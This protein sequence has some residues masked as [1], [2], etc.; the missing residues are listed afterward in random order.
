MSEGILPNLEVAAK[1]IAIFGGAIGGFFGFLKLVKY[2]ATSRKN[3]DN[4]LSAIQT[5]LE[6]SHDEDIKKITEILEE[7]K[8]H[9]ISMKSTVETTVARIDDLKERQDKVE[10]KIDDLG[11]VKKDIEYISKTVTTNTDKLSNQDNRLR[12]I[13]GQNIKKKIRRRK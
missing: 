5:K 10:N 11:G 9:V 8:E 1:V 7:T 6:Q 12:A 4:K 2:I 13:E 3:V